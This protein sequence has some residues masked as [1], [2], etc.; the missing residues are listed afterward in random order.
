MYIEKLKMEIKDIFFNLV[1]FN[2]LNS[3]VFYI[4]IKYVLF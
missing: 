4:K 3:L 1:N 2:L